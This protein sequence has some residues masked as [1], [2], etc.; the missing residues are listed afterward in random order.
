[1]ANLRAGEMVARKLTL[2]YTKSG[3]PLMSISYGHYEETI[4][5]DGFISRYVETQLIKMWGIEEGEAVLLFD[6]HNPLEGPE[7][8]NGSEGAYI[9]LGANYLTGN[10][11]L[12]LDNSSSGLFEVYEIVDGNRVPMYGYR[13]TETIGSD[14]IVYFDNQQLYTYSNQKLWTYEEEKTQSPIKKM[15][16]TNQ[17]DEIKLSSAYFQV[18]DSIRRRCIG[19]FL[20]GHYKPNIP[21]DAPEWVSFYMQYLRCHYLQSY[22]PDAQRPETGLRKIMLTAEAFGD[23]GNPMMSASLEEGLGPGPS[24]VMWVWDEINQNKGHPD[25]GYGF[26]KDSSGRFVMCFNSYMDFSWYEL[27]PEETDFLFADGFELFGGDRA[28][29]NGEMITFT[30]YTSVENWVEEKRSAAFV[31][32]GYSNPVI[33]LPHSSYDLPENSTWP[34]LEQALINYLCTH[35]QNIGQWG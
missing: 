31:Q 4:F 14:G 25:G 3:V 26:Y 34:E 7:L 10:P 1:M 17:K 12:Y 29:A 23:K 30:D 35:A 16:V 2:Y 28:Y 19:D 22:L 21:E 11:I 5:D 32:H 15:P 20:L 27:G 6:R 8:A 18:D 33:P 13:Y 24:Y 9:R